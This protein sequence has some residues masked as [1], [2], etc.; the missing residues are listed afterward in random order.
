MYTTQKSDRTCSS[1]RSASSTERNTATL[2]RGETTDSGQPSLGEQ[3]LTLL[4]IQRI[5]SDLLLF[6][7][8]ASDAVE[9]IRAKGIQ[10]IRVRESIK[11]KQLV[12]G[13]WIRTERNRV[14]TELEFVRKSLV[15]SQD[16]LKVTQNSDGSRKLTREL[17]LFQE[18]ER[19]L[20][21]NLKS[22]EI[23]AQ[24]AG[25]D[26]KALFE[27]TDAIEMEMNAARSHLAAPVPTRPDLT[28]L[29]TRRSQLAKKV[30]P[31]LFDKY[32]RIC[33]AR[34]GVGISR[35]ENGR[36]LACNMQL[37]PQAYNEMLGSTASSHECPACL[38]ILVCAA[39][40]T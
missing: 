4:E 36:C 9:E 34:N 8:G 7:R 3:L 15:S 19:R 5:D 28:E 27:K 21:V 6:A 22:V 29:Q 40:R 39:A 33:E 2:T 24:R 25:A 12:Q 11:E 37:P 38:R 18:Q 17:K 13:E 20:I 16:E 32:S 31:A 23:L 26:L 30:L 35:A 14:R 1:D 10:L